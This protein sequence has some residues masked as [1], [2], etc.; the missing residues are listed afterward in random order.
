MDGCIEHFF[1]R[2]AP[3]SYPL[4]IKLW[5]YSDSGFFFP[6]ERKVNLPELGV[7]MPRHKIS[8]LLVNMPTPRRGVLAGRL[9]PPMRRGKGRLRTGPPLALAVAAAAGHCDAVQLL[10]RSG[11]APAAAA[12][13]ALLC[14]SLSLRVERGLLASQLF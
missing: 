8:D 2:V 3:Y 6:S 14:A 9:G 12:T 11:A 7:W 10:L 13:R 5:D 4:N 1:D